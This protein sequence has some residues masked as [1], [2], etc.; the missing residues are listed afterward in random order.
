[1]PGN[2]KPRKKYRPTAATRH[3]R[4]ALSAEAQGLSLR[5][6]SRERMSAGQL[7]DLNIAVMSGLDSIIK[8][9]GKE[10]DVYHLALASN[11]ALVLAEDGMGP[12]FIPDIKEAQG[13]LTNLVERINRKES[14]LLTGPGIEA[15]R[16]LVQIHEVQVEHE[17]FDEGRMFRAYRT[18]LERMAQGHVLEHGLS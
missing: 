6:A 9:T 5:G 3:G 16:R 17:D 14:L 10:E 12:E 4:I 15:V 8:G 18:I 7:R 11:V 1:M 13:H 2:K